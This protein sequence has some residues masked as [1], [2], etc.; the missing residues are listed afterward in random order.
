MLLSVVPRYRFVVRGRVQGVAF[1][2]HA[3]AEATGL[4]L[5]GF[6]R[7]RADGAV[8]GEADG[9]ERALDAFVRWLHR[10]PP[11]ARVDHVE[12]LAVAGAAREPEF[13]VRR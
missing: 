5:V 4:G 9:D 8:E 11:W 3:R 10:G 1:R 2:A 13:V 7:N 12:W 6:V